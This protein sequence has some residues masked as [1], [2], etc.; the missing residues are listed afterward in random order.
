M[1]TAVVERSPIDS[2]SI[3]YRGVD[4][5][6]DVR[7]QVKMV[8]VDALPKESET[9]AAGPWGL[10]YV[11]YANDAGPTWTYVYLKRGGDLFRIEG[12]PLPHRPITELCWLRP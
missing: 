3:N 7:S 12:M 8:A 10:A 9:P 1:A 6:E 5:T 2:A 11:A 4:L